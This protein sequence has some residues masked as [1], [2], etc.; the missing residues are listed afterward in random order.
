MGGGGALPHLRP[1]ALPP[2]VGAPKTVEALWE[3]AKATDD[4][5]T[6]K[7]L[8]RIAQEKQWLE[9]TVESTPGVLEPLDNA[10]YERAVALGYEPPR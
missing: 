8:R 4:L 10:L 3:A 1:G 6:V 7:S 2:P 9:D 5:V